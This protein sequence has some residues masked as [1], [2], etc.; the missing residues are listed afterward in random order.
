LSESAL[1]EESHCNDPSTQRAAPTRSLRDMVGWRREWHKAKGNAH[2]RSH[3]LTMRS[4]LA[5]PVL[6]CQTTSGLL[7]NPRPRGK[8]APAEKRIPPRTRNKTDSRRS[9]ARLPD[10]RLSHRLPFGPFKIPIW[11]TIFPSLG[12]P[13]V[14]QKEVTESNHISLATGCA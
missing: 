11:K 3:I 7:R 1:T 8:R 10:V 5:V 13:L 2:T 6:H 4:G 12:T 9:A 14:Y